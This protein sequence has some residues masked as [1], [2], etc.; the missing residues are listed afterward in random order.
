LAAIDP[1][2]RA[3]VV[4]I[5]RYEHLAHLREA[6][7]A[8][9]VCDVLASPDYC[10]YPP[11]NVTLLED[12]AASRDRI[13]H[14]LSA[15]C[16]HATLP[17]S[18]TFFYFSGHGGQG[19]DGSSYILPV[20][21][22]RDDYPRTAI[23]AHDLS[24]LVAPCRGELTVVLDCCRAA[25]MARSD[26]TTDT[27]P[28]LA[29]PVS[30]EP[31]GPG[32]DG[33]TD[34][35]RAA[36]RSGASADPRPTR[37]VLIAASRAQGKA[38]RSPDAP[39]SIL[40]GHMLDCLRGAES[41]S[42]AGANVTIDQLFAY[43]ERHVRHD[44]GDAQKPLFIAETETFYPVTNYPRAVARAEVFDKDVF[45]SYHRDDEELAA[46]V[47]NFFQPALEHSGISIWDHDDLGALK[48]DVRVAIQ[49]SRYVIVLLTQA[50]LRQPMRSP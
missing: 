45:I 3:L 31:E 32:L 12:S 44:A 36:I 23:S 11:E 42:R 40:T 6:R 21:A 13:L 25:G 9:G 38:F 8:R 27:G 7:D 30:P 2:P 47:T 10:A 17:G 24:R 34:S 5:S 46:W 28:A 41:D 1:P 15:L 18:R 35:L 29:R 4:G 20:D 43:I 19:P 26:I 49:K 48:V 39:Y 37:R 22:H 14:A 33:F 50:Y 16:E